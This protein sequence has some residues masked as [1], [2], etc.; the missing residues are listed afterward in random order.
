[1]RRE[2]DLLRHD[3]SSSIREGLGLDL[4]Q[5]HPWLVHLLPTTTGH[6]L[7]ILTKQRESTSAIQEGRKNLAYRHF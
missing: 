2:T 1:M 3:A 7:E 4:Q 5:H 6:S